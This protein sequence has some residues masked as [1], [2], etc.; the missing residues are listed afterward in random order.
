M[1]KVQG[2]DILNLI[3]FV[4]TV[5][6]R[7]RG[8]GYI[9]FGKLGALVVALGVSILSPTVWEMIV[10]AVVRAS[11][12]EREDL[13]PAVRLIAAAIVS[14]AGL[15]II[16]RSFRGYHE[17]MKTPEKPTEN[18]GAAGTN[19]RPNTPLEN[20][21]LFI[22]EGQNVS[23]NI[24]QLSQSERAL[25]VTEGP[26]QARDFEEFLTKVRERTNPPLRLKWDGGGEFYRLYVEPLAP[27]GGKVG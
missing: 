15:A 2:A 10:E 25:L 13:S 14:I 18:N 24:D 1:A 3:K 5:W 17:L 19:V 7:R 12:G 6:W 11:I 8:A 26:L 4:F 9:A 21:I 22:A 16:W 20:L 23:V 27:A